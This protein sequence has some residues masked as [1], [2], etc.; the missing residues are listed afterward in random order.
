MGRWI[1][2]SLVAG[3]VLASAAAYGYSG[4]RWRTEALVLKVTGQ[5]PDLSWAD[6][7]PL[8]GPNSGVWPVTIATDRNPHWAVVAPPATAEDV[9][10]GRRVFEQRCVTC[11]GPGLSGGA[12]PDLTTGVFRYGTSDWALFRNL[13]HGIV[14]LPSHPRGLPVDATWQVI[15]FIRSAVLDANPYHLRREGAPVV[16]RDD[17]RA[18]TTSELA[19]APGAGAE[20]L[21][22]SGSYAGH[23]HSPLR[24]IDPSN[25]GRLRLKWMRQL[26][27]PGPS[28]LT[29]LVVGDTMFVTTPTGT[30]QA[31]DT[32]SGAVRWERVLE[33]AIPDAAR[34]VDGVGTR[35]PAVLEHSLFVPTFDGQLYALDTR[36]GR[37][38][39]RVRV[40]DSEIGYSLVGAPL[41]AGGRVIV[42]VAGGD[43]GVRGFLDAYAAGDGG[44]L[45]RF[46]TVPGPGE[47]GHETWGDSD[48][49]QRGGGVTPVTGTYDPELGLVFW[50]VG[51]P[52]PPF[53]GE[54]RPGDNLYTSSVIALEA[55]TGRLRWHYQLNPHDER[56]WGGTVVPVLADLAAPE[57]E[58]AVLHLAAKN[59]FFY[60]LDRATGR[61][62]QAVPFARQTWN[63]GFDDAGRP[64]ELDG[65]RPTPGG[66]LVYPGHAGA[67]GAAPPSYDPARRLFF[68]LTKDGYANILYKSYR[69]EWPDGAVW[70][71]RAG[72]PFGIAVPTELRAI[73][74]HTGTIRWRHRFP[75]TMYSGPGSGGVLSTASG[76]VFAADKQRF[77]AIDSASGIELWH[78]ETGGAVDAAPVSYLRGGIQQI[79]LVA[80][81]VVVTF[82]LDGR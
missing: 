44:R 74:V 58:R 82:S 67:T 61:L 29:P 41:V 4:L 9:A 63:E 64:R 76:L 57:S 56:D 66:T 35:G 48:A 27:G 49:W 78:F 3:V 79:A 23:R 33:V 20:W 6:V 75:G 7:W 50:G 2:W 59:G 14:A 42:G 11:H 39:W 28:L 54:R 69:I 62:R 18:V 17:V 24:E 71:G 77:S 65:T 72:Q 68:L 31:L 8:L 53:Q 45:W 81:G 22:H 80:G 47:P 13:R 40:V 51:A 52:S 10:A 70:G 37:T 36:S 1:G 16:D 12:A 55:A 25:V 26:P 46:D 19:A 43:R 5:M 15:A 30:V 32:V 73:D 60:T 21:V 38:L 34:S